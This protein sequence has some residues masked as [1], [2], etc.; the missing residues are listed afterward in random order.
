M[1]ACFINTIMNI[2]K[3]AKRCERSLQDQIAATRV[4]LEMDDSPPNLWSPSQRKEAVTLLP[5]DPKE[6]AGSSNRSL[7]VSS[8]PTVTYADLNSPHAAD[9]DDDF[10]LVRPSELA[11][12]VNTNDFLFTPWR[13]PSANSFN[14]KRRGAQRFDINTYNEGPY[15]IQTPQE[16]VAT[17]ERSSGQDTDQASRAFAETVP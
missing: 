15:F 6:C 10:V 3:S 11:Q 4:C 17:P 2:D 9:F 1:R 5:A 8:S 16:A 7:E 13:Q 14:L 12:Q